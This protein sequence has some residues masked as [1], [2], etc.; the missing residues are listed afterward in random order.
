MSQ[1]G[2]ASAKVSRSSEADGCIERARH[3][4]QKYWCTSR[5]APLVAVFVVTL[6]TR[7][8]RLKKIGAGLEKAP[9][10]MHFSKF[11]IYATS[12]A[13]TLQLYHSINHY[14]DHHV[15]PRNGTSG[16]AKGP[17]KSHDFTPGT[18]RV[19]LRVRLHIQRARRPRRI[20]HQYRTS[21]QGASD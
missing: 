16:G 20:P 12:P 21:R 15:W 6:L 19:H 10:F 11:H 18:P 9:S 7:T 17:T 8:K 4:Q 2:S 3:S 5:C 1:S 13:R 14:Y